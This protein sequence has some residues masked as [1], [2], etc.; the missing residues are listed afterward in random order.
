MRGE[1]GQDLMSVANYSKKQS[2]GCRHL[3]DD[4]DDL[5]IVRKQCFVFTGFPVGLSVSRAC[6]HALFHP[7]PRGVPLTSTETHDYISGCPGATGDEAEEII[8]QAIHP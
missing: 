8:T 7:Q 1:R 3:S 4:W 6:A 5:V 2:G